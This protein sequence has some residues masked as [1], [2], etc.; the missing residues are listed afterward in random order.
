MSPATIR[1]LLLA[2]CVSVGAVALL[3][4]TFRFDGGRRLLAAREVID[5]SADLRGVEPLDVLG[6]LLA[7]VNEVS[8]VHGPLSFGSASDVSRLSLR[9]EYDSG[10]L[11]LA[12]TLSWPENTTG[13]DRASLP[14]GR[15]W[16]TWIPIT[17]APG[18]GPPISGCGNGNRPGRVPIPAVRRG[19]GR[20]GIQVNVTEHA[21]LPVGA[22]WTVP[23]VDGL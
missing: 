3:T 15:A 2:T 21:L 13:F 1:P 17:S 22:R 20:V 18:L 5:S 7:P 4:F 8:Q 16:L 11:V 10:Q 23:S 12:S 6:A 9:L 19:D 14:Q